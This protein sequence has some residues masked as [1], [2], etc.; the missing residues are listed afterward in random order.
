VTA[1]ARRGRGFG[2]DV[3]LLAAA[4]LATVVAFFGVSVVGARLLSPEALGSAAV[5][6]TIGMI[7]ALVANGGLNIATIYFLQQR[8]D[9]RG[10]LVQRLGALAIGGSTVAVVL[11]GI[12]APIVMGSV[13]ADDAW[14]L[15][16]AAAAMGAAM[17]A[18][19]FAGALLL[20]LGRAGGF[21]IMELVRG[22]G[23]LA[24]V[25]ILLAGP[26][27]EDGGF[28]LG[29][30]LGYAAAALLGLVGTRRSGLSL[31]PSFDAAF[32]AEALSFGLKGQ[33][34]NIFQFL[35]VRLDLLLVPALL[36]LRAAGIYV[37]AVRMSDVVGQAATAASSLV[38]PRV[39]GQLEAGSTLLTE[40]ATRMILIVVAASALVLGV[41]GETVL[42][43]AFGS[44]YATGTVALLVLLV[45]TLP[46]SLGRLVAADLKGRGRPDLVS[47]AALL[48]VVATVA[49]DLALIPLLGI[50]G[51][52]LASVIAYTVSAAALLIGYRSV[53]GG[54]LSALV[55]RPSDV[56]ELV[57]MAL[58]LVTGRRPRGGAA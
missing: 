21:T 17:I 40:R 35:G 47:W 28:V 41:A 34:G 1:T 30:G 46:L 24:A 53:T 18:F 33:V 55:P 51:A 2:A 54:R 3:A 52:A 58:G 5:G 48:T 25:T 9:E 12:S 4:R 56:R 57:A 23:S 14:P 36:D 42:R 49:A 16:G 39:A 38:F 13:V 6:Q 50:E 27:R 29:L 31:R 22:I 19:E 45:A 32:T 10:A 20:G 7:A 11:V 8:P 15:M 37:I 44:I 26:W 43:I